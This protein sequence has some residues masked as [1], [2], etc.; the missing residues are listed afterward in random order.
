MKDRRLPVSSEH[1]SGGGEFVRSGTGKA[2]W[3]PVTGATMLSQVDRAS[4]FTLLALL[5]S[6]TARETGEAMCKPSGPYK[7]FVRTTAIPAK[8]PIF[9]EGVFEAASLPEG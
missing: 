1:T 9:A 2:T 4:R 8:A 6:R 7:E 5:G 3:A